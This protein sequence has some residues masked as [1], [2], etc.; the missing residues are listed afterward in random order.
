VRAFRTAGSDGWTIASVPMAGIFSGHMLGRLRYIACLLWVFLLLGSLEGVTA[1]EGAPDVADPKPAGNTNR[2]RAEVFVV[3]D[4]AATAAFVPNAAVVRRL[5]ERGITALAG[6]ADIT[7]AW[8][9]LIRTNDVVGFKVTS[10]AGEVG[11]TR[12]SVVKGLVETLLAAGHPPRQIVIWDKRTVDLRQAGWQT[13]ASSLG[14]R[15]QSSEDAGWDPNPDRAYEKPVIGRLV[16]GDLEFDRRQDLNAGRRSYVTR[17]LTQELTVVI[18]VTPVLAHNLAG[19]NGQLV[20]LALGSI[21][22]SLRF[23][24]NPALLAEAVP[25]ICA[26]D[27]LLPRVVFGV[28]DA[29]ICQYR[30]EES[31]R[32]Y[33][34]VILNELRFSRDPLALDALALD[35]IVRAHKA[36]PYAVGKLYE[37]D[38]YVNAELLELGVSDLKRI[39]VKKGK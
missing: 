31:L 29:L 2:P 32:L 35:D 36:S 10:A 8:R 19:V 18:P 13:L 26:L 15:C 14:V 27:D 5:V 3:Q 1:A 38:L 39:D 6:K 9:A 28:S 23:Q 34:T 4:P 25:E 11:G 21:D 30:G 33:D 20:G 7:N 37:T 16:A 24:N 22:N 17:L 12:P